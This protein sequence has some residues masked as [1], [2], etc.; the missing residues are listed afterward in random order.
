[1][2]HF[3]NNV[4][5]FTLYLCHYCASNKI[6]V[7]SQFEMSEKKLT[8]MHLRDKNML[9]YLLENLYLVMNSRNFHTFLNRDVEMTFY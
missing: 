1:M 3:F 4:H 5:L 2:L 7:L 9:T 8:F 6:F